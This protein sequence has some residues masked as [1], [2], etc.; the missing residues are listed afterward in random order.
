V[1]RGVRGAITVNDNSEHAIIA[2]TEELVEKM[3]ELNDINPETVASVFISTTDDLNAAFP[4]KA[5]R[6]FSGWTYVP[7]MCMRELSVPN[8]LKL[9]VRIMMHVNT[10]VPQGKIDHV[11]LKG[12]KVLRPD[13]GK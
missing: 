10:D 11:Y 9:C 5:L 2:A 1:I 6:S 12:A 3:I 7:V 8:S 4:A 13:L